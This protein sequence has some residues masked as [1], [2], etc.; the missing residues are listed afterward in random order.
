MPAKSKRSRVTKKKKGA[1]LDRTTLILVGV[2]VIVIAITV[3]GL[4]FTQQQPSVASDFVPKY[5]GG[6][7]IEVAEAVIDHGDVKFNRFVESVF[8]IQN[9]GDSPLRIEDQPQVVLLDG[10]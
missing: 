8:H 1:A 7:R 6:P 3:G 5:T 4:L 10:C 2:A 9:V